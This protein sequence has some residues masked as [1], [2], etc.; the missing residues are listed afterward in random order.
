MNNV[1]NETGPAVVEASKKALNIRYSL[2]PYLYTLF[3]QAHSK[4]STVARPLFFEFPLDRQTYSIDLQFLWGSALMIAPVLAED[5]LQV[6]VYLPASLWYDY[7][8]FQLVSTGGA[9]VRCCTGPTTPKKR[10]SLAFL[11][12]D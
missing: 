1:V 8:S 10:A 4:G 12:S 5:T 9:W 3:W 11:F 6:E 2:L 7:Y